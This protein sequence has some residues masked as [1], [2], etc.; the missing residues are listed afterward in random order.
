MAGVIVDL[1]NFTGEQKWVCQI[2]SA[3][4]IG[5]CLPALLERALN[6]RPTYAEAE[7]KN[8][9]MSVIPSNCP[10]KYRLQRHAP[11]RP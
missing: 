2:C 11:I 7:K 3:R 1:E 5:E 9:D 4:E 10:N 8:I 6:R